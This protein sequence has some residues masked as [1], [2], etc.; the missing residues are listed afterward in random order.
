MTPVDL[1]AVRR[2]ADAATPGPWT[3]NDCQE[4]LGHGDAPDAIIETDSGCYGPEDYDR[5]FIAASRTLVPAMADE[6]AELRD[7]SDA[8]EAALKSVIRAQRAT[9]AALR[10]SLRR[11]DPVLSTAQVSAAE[12]G[13]AAYCGAV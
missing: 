7:A 5:A 3:W 6:I 8:I 13:D 10:E 4:M 2:L 11:C 1:D 9:I 12:A